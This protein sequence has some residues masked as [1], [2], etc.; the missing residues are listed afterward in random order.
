MFIFHMYCIYL[1]VAVSKIE[2]D[3]YRVTP[4]IANLGGT[5]AQVNISY[6]TSTATDQMMSL[7]KIK[8][9]FSLAF[10]G[11]GGSY[12]GTGGTGY[13][14][15]PPGPAYNDEQMTDL[16]GGSGGCMRGIH[17]YEINAILG[18]PSGRGGH[19]GGAIEV[20]AAND[21]VIGTYGHISMRGED[22]QQ[23]SGGGGGGGGSGGAILLSAGGVI[24]NEGESFH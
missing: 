22:G 15:N 20:I 4:N 10:G 16:L 17:P 13:G 5:G 7:L 14:L 12:G 19:G 24:V 21:I 2:S 11:G 1:Y 9:P 8:T 23:A 3:Y 18:S 6:G